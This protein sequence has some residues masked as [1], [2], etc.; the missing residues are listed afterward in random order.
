MTPNFRSIYRYVTLLLSICL[1]ISLVGPTFAEATPGEAK[2]ISKKESLSAKIGELPNKLPK[3][4]LELTSK[5]TPFSKRYLN[6]DGSFT[7]E[8]FM[9]QQFYQD[10]SD[11]KWKKVDN[12]LKNSNENSE[13]FENKANNQEAMFT[14]E[15]GNGELVT[16]EKKDKNISLIP[17]KANKVHGTIKENT[18]SY[19]GIFPKVDVHYR[20]QG[21]AVKEDIVLNE[22]QNDNTFS[23]ELKVK[24]VT[25]HKEKNGTIV[26]KDSKG[27]TVWFFEEP[28]MT[29]KKGKYSEKV[30]L[31]LREEK[32]KTY[33]DVIA[34]QS[35]LQDKDTAYPVT[36]DPTINSWDVVR[37]HF[38]ASNFPNSIYS[39]NTY[40]HTGYNSYFGSTR[41]LVQFFLPSLPSDSKIS[42]STFHAYQTQSGTA[43]SVIDLFR[44]TNDWTSSVSWNTQPS[45][46][47]QLEA[48]TTSNAVNAYWKWDVTKL[49]KDWY[50]GDQANYGFM[51]KQQ[52]ETSSPYRTFTSVNNGVNTPRLT[53][54]YTVDPIGDE[55]F[56]VKTEEGINPSNGNLLLNQTD[57]SVSGRG[58]EVNVNR[59]Y[60]SRKSWFAGMF[61]YGWFSNTEVRLIDAG[62]GPITIIDGDNTR[63]I[64][65][66]E[67]G[68]GYRAAGG[69]FLWLD[70]E[71][72]GTYTLSESDNT[73]YIF[74]KSG[75]LISKID[76]NGNKI[77][78]NYS[79]DGKLSNIQDAS[80]RTTY[81]TYGT[82][83]YV[84]SIT[85]PA[86]RKTM[87]EY[88]ASGNLT[89]VIDPTNSTTTFSYDADHN[90]IN[91]TD[92]RSIKTTIDYDTSDRVKSVSRPITVNSVSEASI[93]TYSYDT[94]NTVTTVTDGEGKR[95][96]YS[97]N[98]NGN[99]VQIT[100]NPLDA[101][102]K[103]VTTFTYDNN[104][105]LIKVV[106]ANTNKSG[107]TA[108]YIYTYDDKGNVT[109]VQLPEN[110]TSYFGYDEENNLTQ[111]QDF[112]ENI[113]DFDY[114][115]NSNQTEAVDA[116]QQTVAQRYDPYGNIKNITHPLSV[117]DNHLDNSSFELDE[118]QDNWPDKWTKATE[119]GKTAS[120]ARETSFKYGK[121]S[122]SI[123][124]PSGWAVISGEKMAYSPG[125]EYIVSGYMK[126]ENATGAAI[127][128]IEFFD[129]DNVWLGQKISYG[130]KGT[131]DW[132]RVQA[133]VK[134]VP[135]NT[136]LLRVSVGMNAGSGKA[137]F[138]GVQLEKGSVVGAYNL[139]ENASFERNMNYWETSNLST[140]DGIDQTQA[141]V[142]SK[143]FK[144]TGESQKNKYIKQRI[145]ISGNENNRFTLSGWSKQ[146]GANST[147]GY[148]SLQVGIHYTDGT[149]D[150][151]NAND[152]NKTVEDWQHVAAEVKPTKEFDYIEVYYYFFNQTGSA[153]FDAIRLEDGA[154]HLY[155]NYNNH[156]YLISEKDQNENTV[157]YSYDGVGNITGLK[158][159][160]A[161]TTSFKYNAND[162]LIEVVD[163]SQGI[164]SYAYDNVGNRISTTDSKGNLTKYEYNEF[165]EISRI[166]NPLNQITKYE[167]NKNGDQSKIIYPNGNFIS[168]TYDALNRVEK[169]LYNGVE[170][171]KF[172]YDAN[173]NVTTITD[174]EGKI[175]SFS[176]DKNDQ[177]LEEAY[178]N[179]KINYNYDGNGST[180]SLTAL[181][182][183]NQV[184]LGFDYNDVDKLTSLS[185][186]NSNLARFIYDERGNITS[187]INSNGTYT[188]KDYDAGNRLKSLRNY[189]D[190]GQL[191]STYNY[192][193]DEND[194]WINVTTD[195]G[196]TSY[197][198]DSLNQLTQEILIDG[199]IIIYEYDKA[200]NR[201]KKII[202]KDLQTTTQT[203]TYDAGN[204]LVAAD[205]QEYKYDNNGNLLSNGNKIYVYDEENRLIELKD[206]N[207]SSIAKYTY[208]YKGRRKSMV[209]PTG[210]TNFHYNGEDKVIYETDENN[211]IITE[212]TWSDEG[213]PVT[214]TK[215]DKTYYYHLNG[216][217]D[218]TMLTD[219]NGEVVAQYEYDSWGNILSQSGTIALSNPYRYAGY[220]FDEQAGLY[221][222]LTR[223][224]DPKM[225]RFITED[226]FSGFED[227][228]QGLNLYIYTKNNP[229]TYSDPDGHYWHIVVMVGGRLAIKYGPKITKATGK[230]IKKLKNKSFDSG[231]AGENFIRSITGGKSK[232]FQT[233]KSLGDRIVDSYVAG[234][235]TAHE[236]KVGRASKTAFI[237]KQIQKDVWLRKNKPNSVRYIVWHFMRSAKTGKKG[238]TGPLR[239]YLN[240]N[241]IKIV[242]SY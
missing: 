141:F 49:V 112:N 48:S 134:D 200:G 135:A 1:I 239:A 81:F 41:G 195:K 66:E 20:V 92:A 93:T 228:P 33:V 217:K 173:G 55:D 47:N 15:A 157:D 113:S 221:Y 187:V 19:K 36:I 122:V 40:M 67:I 206:Q 242:D 100:E 156:G 168:H 138:D 57:V 65:G 28:Y 218:V 145:N 82:N 91:I 193:Y 101:Q 71:S 69:V 3:E 126:T 62:R 39:S 154:S 182:G 75:K 63:H 160:K 238:P 128:K 139:V 124:N 225:G 46:A 188:T 185:R 181:I 87:Y 86:N 194:N 78:Y 18:V 158:D 204:R 9:D 172:G 222:L 13:K 230:A 119:S 73:K 74:D 83:G 186:N 4:K 51:L 220:R 70:K 146:E 159:G 56:W 240:S 22:Y 213:N 166:I 164:T 147:G 58:P 79:S 241:R 53:V 163:A 7:E 210:T 170:K 237:K 90:L 189:N 21:S 104:N 23:F 5:R 227:E 76:K 72:D 150:W 108:A 121:K 31:N 89:K 212:Y 203:Y 224:Y 97:Y 44:I 32:G 191:L 110:Q 123:S 175:T 198:Y 50:N 167:Y 234:T 183:T 208:D 116:Y 196:T 26:F 29:D 94:T 77:T 171:W 136:S 129:A 142:G 99:V 35:F 209:T 10:P 211:N 151:S 111:E 6:P 144:L 143:S 205:G 25:P 233:T 27:K 54:N 155:K 60:N 14:K 219:S 207:G 235:K 223:Y 125:Q 96:D 103:T 169:T 120:F 140:N 12:N 133:H 114:D 201:T 149:V 84:S 202:K 24:G 184:K 197:Q 161:K 52:N 130:L 68:G 216:H 153:W 59:A 148:Y 16:V 174:K 38:I 132:T 88:D 177:V 98:G 61:G 85:D 180:T 215:G 115:E 226:T 179:N 109:G 30:S 131:H 64:F 232:R 102:N 178:E 11:K 117:A 105:N 43:N 152:F 214:M 199:T 42:S 162:Q 17:V 231:A 80:G 165:D 176:Y 137:Y 95:A 37:D 8:I 107:G 127:I 106:D 190:E 2:R 118:N 229:V 236:A 192:K 34:D 45:V